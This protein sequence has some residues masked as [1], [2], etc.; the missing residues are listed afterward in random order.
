[1]MLEALRAA[2]EV[3]DGMKKHGLDY[4]TQRDKIAEIFDE[5]LLN[6]DWDATVCF[7]N[8]SF[9]DLRII[10][11]DEYDQH[12]GESDDVPKWDNQLV[13]VCNVP[14]YVWFA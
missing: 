1:M 11:E 5:R 7:E 9:R 4:S 12:M 2:D 10:Q 14:S 8:P 13:Y 6:G 3:V